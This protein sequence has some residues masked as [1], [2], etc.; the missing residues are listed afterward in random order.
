MGIFFATYQSDCKEKTLRDQIT[1][2]NKGEFDKDTFFI[3]EELFRSI[4]GRPLSYWIDQESLNC[5]FTLSKLEGSSFTVKHGTSTSDDFR[6]LRLWWEAPRDVGYLSLSKGGEYSKFYSEL[7]LYINWN[8]GGRELS[9]FDRSIIRNPGFHK[10]PGLTWS[11]R[12]T[13]GLSVRVLNENCIFADKGPGIFGQNN[14]LKMLMAALAIL[15]S[16]AFEHLLTVQLA[17]V[18]AAARSYEIGI[19]QNTPFPELDSNTIELLAS[20]ALEA[21]S[22]KYQ[23]DRLNEV[24]HSFYLPLK[25]AEKKCDYKISNLSERYIEI[26]KLINDKCYDL[27]GFKDLKLKVSL[28]DIEHDKLNNISIFRKTE[29]EDFLSWI[30]GVVFG[31]FAVNPNSKIKTNINFSTPF[32]ALK[33][34]SDAM[35]WKKIDT[36]NCEGIFEADLS[37]NHLARAMN[38]VMDSIQIKSSFNVT[39]WMNKAFFDYHI[40]RYTKSRRQAPIYWPLSTPS[41]SYTLWLYY[42]RINNQ[43]L[44]TCVNDFVDPKLKQVA[45]DINQFRL[46]KSRSIQEEKDLEKF[47]NFELELT[48]FREELLHVA[49]FWKPNLNDGVQITAAP[50]WKFFQYKPWQ[51]K[52]KKTWKKLEKGDYDWAHLAHSI[53]PE[54]VKEKCKKD[55]SLAIA[56]NLEELYEES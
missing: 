48:D 54:R 50:L 19:L 32:E 1:S 17:A 3:D 47:I 15:N 2:V 44:Y 42:H 27:F 12:T 8:Q 23:I 6:F 51:K 46:K 13:K 38:V 41:S 29:E 22:I 56:H 43:S 36:N 18:D 21:W 5:Y 26:Q 11:R 24:S 39:T 49:Q 4:P 53:W 16:A 35:I 37:T 33:P 14:D 20:L 10:R 45:G 34:L 31:R 55:K 52:L 9:N 25:I 30:V 40:G 28:G 7:Y